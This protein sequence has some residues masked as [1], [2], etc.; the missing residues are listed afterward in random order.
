M[1]EEE[2]VVSW[3]CIA[4]CMGG[5]YEFVAIGVIGHESD[6]EAFSQFLAYGIQVT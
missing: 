1:Q 5:L 3:T 2:S 4:F 6:Q